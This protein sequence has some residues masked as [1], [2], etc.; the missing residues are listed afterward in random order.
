MKKILLGLFAVFMSLGLACGSVFIIDTTVHSL[1]EQSIEKE[2]QEDEEIKANASGYWSDYI[3]TGWSGEVRNGRIY[4]DI[5]NEEHLARLARNVNGNYYYEYNGTKYYFSNAYVTLMNDIDLSA[6]YWT[7]IGSSAYSTT[8][9]WWIFSSTTWHPYYFSGHFDGNGHTISGMTIRVYGADDIVSKYVSGNTYTY[10]DETVSFTFNNCA[11]IGLFGLTVGATIEDFTLDDGQIRIYSSGDNNKS[12]WTHVGAAVGLLSGGSISNVKNEGVTISYT[13]Y[14]GDSATASY[15]MSI[16]G[17]VGTTIGGAAVSYCSNSVSISVYFY[18]TAQFRELSIGGIAGVVSYDIYRCDCS[19]DIYL[20][21]KNSGQI[22]SV[23]V[24]FSGI[25]SLVRS[26]KGNMWCYKNVFSGTL[27]Y[28]VGPGSVI[29]TVGGIVANLLNMS[30]SRYKVY[31]CTNYG[32]ITVTNVYNTFVGGV[33]AVNQSNPIEIYSCSNFGD[34]NLTLNSDNC[35]D[36]GYGGILGCSNVNGTYIYNS[37][38]YGDINVRAS[39]SIRNIGGI[40]GWILDNGL[41]TACINHGVI[42]GSSNSNSVGG[43]AGQIG[44]EYK[45]GSWFFDVGHEDAKTNVFISNCI[46]YSSVTGSS[47]YGQIVGF[48]NGENKVYNCYG[49]TNYTSGYGSSSSGTRKAYSTILGLSFLT[50]NNWTTASYAGYSSIKFSVST[51]VS[52][53]WYMSPLV[54]YYYSSTERTAKGMSTNSNQNI[55]VPKGSVSTYSRVVLQWS[56]PG[57]ENNQSYSSEVGYIYYN[58]WNSTTNKMEAKTITNEYTAFPYLNGAD[59]TVSYR[60]ENLLWLEYRP[61]HWSFSKFEIRYSDSSE[62]ER[63]YSYNTIYG[64][65][66]S[67]NKIYVIFR[68]NSLID[69]SY[70]YLRF[71]LDS[72]AQ[73]IDVSNYV[74]KSYNSTL[75]TDIIASNNGGKGTVNYDTSSQ[76]YASKKTYYHDDISLTTVPKVGYA[77]KKIDRVSE[78]GNNTI[79]TSNFSQTESIEDPTGSTGSYTT[80]SISYDFFNYEVYFVPIVYEYN[81]V[82]NWDFNQPVENISMKDIS[83]NYQMLRNLTFYHEDISRGEAGDDYNNFIYNLEYGYEYYFYLIDTTNSA[84]SATPNSKYLIKSDTTGYVTNVELSSDDL[85]NGLSKLN[86]ALGK[87]DFTIY[88]ERKAIDYNIQ[89]HNMITSYQDTDLY[90][91]VSSENFHNLVFGEISSTDYHR[92]FGEKMPEYSDGIFEN[93]DETSLIKGFKVTSDDTKTTEVSVITDYGAEN[94][95]YSRGKYSF[96]NSSSGSLSQE[97]N[98]KSNFSEM[99]KTYINYFRERDPSKLDSRTLDVYVYSDLQSY[100]VNGEIEIDDEIASDNSMKITL[101]T[102]E[103]GG[104]NGAFSSNGQWIS[105]HAPVTLVADVPYGYDFVGWYLDENLLSLDTEYT[106]INNSL[107]WT[108]GDLKLT[109]AYTTY[110]TVSGDYTENVNRKVYS[111]SSADDLV[112]LSE[113][114]SKGNTFEGVTFNQTADINMSG[115]VFNPIGSSETPFKGI[116]NGKN[117]TIKNLKI[118]SVILNK[119]G[120]TEEKY[121]Y[122]LSYRGLFGYVDGAVIKNLTLMD[123]EVTGYSYI[124][125]IVGYAK[126]STLESLNSYECEVYSINDVYSSTSLSLD[127]YSEFSYYDI[128]GNQTRLYLTTNVELEEFE[129]QIACSGIVGYAEDCTFFACSINNG[130]I[131][132]AFYV[133]GIVGYAEDC[134]LNQCFSNTH[135]YSL[136]VQYETQKVIVGSDSYQVYLNKDK[137]LVDKKVYVATTVS[138]DLWTS[139]HYS[140]SCYEDGELVRP[141]FDDYGI[142]TSIFIYGGKR[143]VAYDCYYSVPE[144]KK[145]RLIGNISSENG[146][147]SAVNGIIFPGENVDLDSDIWITVNGKTTLKVFYWA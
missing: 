126:N 139:A 3:G 49:R 123:G 45:K 69:T 42:S 131:R 22:A 64:S 79:I 8:E 14:S 96:I 109:A 99:L 34:L 124:G 73:E 52:S 111:V 112:W 38:N 108:S 82:S 25:V 26:T 54:Y 31:E 41:I 55:I 51:T 129:E 110:D 9:G 28:D 140:S 87:L 86:D 90:T 30:G 70:L 141:Y 84:P 89:L 19:A 81:I 15:S 47:N 137:N 135:M 62:Y 93:F 39:K 116:Y 74:Y 100:K 92:Y 24:Y 56:K 119:D 80:S 83:N 143:N 66:G 44:K 16:G 46:N 133:S 142:N 97:F 72:I 67:N 2:N 5:Y 23:G 76:A 94:Y 103:N 60:A 114:V 11:T 115:V 75:N 104:T 65:N 29:N 43:I 107:F 10:G 132:G 78:L 106:Y 61:A 68:N 146:S 102:Q 121:K 77:V 144:S 118:D 127:T 33:V 4:Y 57:D 32:D 63:S 20:E 37:A 13:Q 98:L 122:N 1:Q 7:P 50:G 136:L 18:G 35:T 59:Y 36:S 134:T 48:I 6:H 58:V 40:A 53:N 21:A 120:T 101:T 125:G 88:I 145:I 95:G 138:D 17:V 85:I 105:Y 91:E 130:F 147:L 71:T 12:L 117:Y 27:T 128:Y 113:Q